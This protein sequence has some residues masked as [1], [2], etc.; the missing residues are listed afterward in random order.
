MSDGLLLVLS[1][2]GAVPLEE[3]H[4][5]Y[6][7]DHAPARVALPGVHGGE[8]FR[9]VDGA[10]P[11][12]LAVYPLRLDA[13][14]SAAYAALRVR[15]PSERD[16]VARLGALDRRV[17][18]RLPGIGT[19][20]A[21]S[22]PA[23]GAAPLLLTV[24]FTSTDPRGLED[25]YLREH[26]PLL[27]ALPGW[28]RCT[29]FRRLE[30]SGPEHLAVHELASADVFDDPGYRRATSTPWRER[31]MATVVARERRLFAHHRTV[32]AQR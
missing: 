11:D 31:V 17:Y 2:P 3:F 9:A 26:L 25:W 28:L 8:R 32:T 13:L 12:W 15:S 24:G 23:P 4:R 27:C 29:R 30:G 18:E 10:H 19:G 6:D 7:D 22:G 16:V 14:E 20:D 21:G 5:W 1:A